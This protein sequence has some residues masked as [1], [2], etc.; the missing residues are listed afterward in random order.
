[1]IAVFHSL[2]VSSMLIEHLSVCI[3][4]NL[5]DDLSDDKRFCFGLIFVNKFLFAPENSFKK[6]D[7]TALNDNAAKSIKKG[8]FY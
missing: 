7:L 6:Q 4:L 1:M 8:A 5:N 2:G 3:F